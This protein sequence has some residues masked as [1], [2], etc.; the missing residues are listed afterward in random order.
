VDIPALF[1]EGETPGISGP[2]ALT[3][4]IPFTAFYDGTNSPATFTYVTSDTTAT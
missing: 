1:L 2:D 3:M 4:S